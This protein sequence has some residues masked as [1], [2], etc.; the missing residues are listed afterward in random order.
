M[1]AGDG[2]ANGER[3]SD[4][5][6]KSIPYLEVYNYA[7]SGVGTDQ[8]Y[9][10]YLECGDVD[11]DL[12]IIGVTTDQ[13]NRS[14]SHVLTF[15]DANG[16]EVFY[17]KP[18]YEIENNKLVLHNV[19]V[20]KRPWT[21]ETIPQEEASFV[22]TGGRM[23]P[24]AQAALRPLV[25]SQYFRRFAAA[26]GLRDLLRPFKKPKPVPDYD[27]PDNP[28]W[29][30]LRK[31]L[32]TWVHGS[33]TPVL[34]IPIPMWT[35]MEGTSDATAY[36]TRFRELE[37]ETKCDLHD[38]LPDLLAYPPDQRRGFRFK[39]DLHLSPKGH[40]AMARSLA[41]T[42]ERIIQESHRDD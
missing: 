20:P 34:I 2:V 37:I 12:L 10:S 22:D 1:T 6:Q 7:L 39:L 16:R 19:P 14:N 17:A 13:I 30:R 36:Q 42:I 32:E 40:Q 23:F 11:H 31:I 3:F 28:G 26:I 35:Q 25:T 33:K 38:P 8:Q 9:L 5:L 27:S 24:R 4:L 29:L 41:P 18:Y 21:K 15:R